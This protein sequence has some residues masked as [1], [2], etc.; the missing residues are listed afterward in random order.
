MKFLKSH[1]LKDEY[2]FDRQ[3]LVIFDRVLPSTSNA[4]FSS[5]AKQIEHITI[6]ERSSELWQLYVAKDLGQRDHFGCPTSNAIHLINSLQRINANI[7]FTFIPARCPIY[8]SDK[9]RITT[10]LSSPENYLTTNISLLT[11]NAIPEFSMSSS[12]TK[13]WSAPAHSIGLQYQCAAQHHLSQFCQNNNSIPSV[14]LGSPFS[15]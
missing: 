2:P 7:S 5:K 8:N 4:G 15:S 6:S 3:C 14:N 10:F 12:I 13:R 1:H 11:K 9:F